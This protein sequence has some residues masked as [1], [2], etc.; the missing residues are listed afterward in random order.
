ML[1]KFTIAPELRFAPL[2]FARPVLRAYATYAT[3]GDGFRGLVGGTA[4]DGTTAGA[5]FGVQMEAWW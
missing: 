2:F 5:N 4:F 1:Y 3:W